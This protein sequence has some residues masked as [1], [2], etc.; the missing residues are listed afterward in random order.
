VKGLS[1]KITAGAFILAL[2]MLGGVSAEA[3][4]NIQKLIESR[5]SVEHTHQVL[6]T[7][8]DILLGMEDAEKGRRGYAF[9][10]DDRE[11]ATLQK[12]IQKTNQA[13]K[14]VQQLTQDNPTQQHHLNELVPLVKKRLWL[15]Q[16]FV[17]QQRNNAKQSAQVATIKQ[18]LLLQED[19]QAKLQIME[20]EERTLL[21]QRTALIDASVQWAAAI[22]GIGYCLSFAMLAGTF[23]LLQ[24]QIRVRKQAEFALTQLN[25]ELE[26]RVAERTA[27]LA[28][29]NE[30]LQAE[31]IERQRTEEALLTSEKQLRT[32]TDALPVLI[33]YIDADRCYRF[34]NRSYEQW[35][36]LSRTEVTGKP[37]RQ[38]LGESA[39]Q[40]IEPYIETVFS[41]REVTYESKLTYQHGGIRWIKATYIPDFEEKG[42]IKGYFALVSDITEQ[43]HAEAS[44]QESEQRL[45]LAIEGAEIA[46][47]D[48]DVR[49]GK[50][51]WSARHFQLLGYDPVPGGEATLEMWQSRVH[52]N[53]LEEVMQAAERAIRERS[54]YRSEHRIIR[55]N[56]GKVVWAAAFGQVLYDEA[57][58][59]VRFVGVILDITDRRQAQQVLQQAKEDLEIKVKERT[60]E[61]N[62][63]NKDLARS[64]QEL[65]QFAYVASHDLQE[66]LRAI[67]G[68]TQLLIEDCQDHLDESTREY[69][70]YIV[71]G[72]RRMQQLIQDLLTYSRIGSRDLV[73]TMT[74]CN[75]VLRQVMSNLQVAIAENH[76]TIT[77]D[78]LPT[79]TADRNQLIQLFQNLIGNAIKFHREEPPQVWISADRQ[80]Q[81][82]LFRV[83]DNGIGIKPRYLER[84][85]EV[86][87][88][89]HTR[90]EFPGTG[91]GLA[92]C[93][94]II[95]RHKGRIWAESEP[96]VGTTFYFTIPDYDNS[97][98]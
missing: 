94:K 71:D 85:F 78:S 48:V 52:P 98:A 92:I 22:S 44:L 93:K 62:Q 91:I 3:Y 96:G 34:N 89:F 55:V 86:F 32:I 11:L 27:E 57:G 59:A 61:L 70:A 53:D 38:I 51:F 65:E 9:L 60:A 35:F 95:D 23:L 64:N 1:E 2:L 84:I 19:I 88:R 17:N 79:L 56:D 67:T 7:L 12:G 90:N 69:T 46:T 15:L 74:N 20:N 28:H 37:L 83:Q 26:T 6:Q 54:I 45:S 81:E 72:A 97:N 47:W 73:F 49:T 87:K 16:K 18:T 29:T 40:Q 13:I 5:K 82:W 58:E 76:A 75:Q 8:S 14:T 30:L 77:Y 39:Y 50:A 31:L 80:N 25:K 4:F 66:P 36:G 10:K 41:G 24:K 42:T 43:K 33:S 21:Q 68:Y 63:L